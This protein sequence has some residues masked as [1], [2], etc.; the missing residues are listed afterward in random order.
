MKKL[1]QR[2][3]KKY[4]RDQEFNADKEWLIDFAKEKNQTSLFDYFI[5]GH[6]HLVYDYKLD[7]GSRVLNL[8]DWISF[9]SYAEWNGNELEMKFYKEPEKEVFI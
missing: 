1:S 9:F 6:R 7:K 2:D 8:G 3:S 4:T 5:F